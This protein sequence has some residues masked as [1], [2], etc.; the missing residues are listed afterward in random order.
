[1][2]SRNLFLVGVL[3][4]A[5]YNKITE[6]VFLK[7]LKN[8]IYLNKYK[9]VSKFI[10]SK[11]KV[12]IEG[13]YGLHYIRP[14]NIN[15]QKGL[16]VKNAVDQTSYILN[17]LK[18]IKSNQFEYP[19]FTFRAVKDKI[20]IVCIKCRLSFSQELNAHIKGQGCPDCA[21]PGAPS[22]TNE[23]FLKRVKIFNKDLDILEVYKGYHK[24]LLFRNKYGLCKL[25]PEYLMSGSE[26]TLRVAVNKTEYMK[27]QFIEKHG[28]KYTYP[29]F[30]YNGNREYA[31]INCKDHGEFEQLTDVHLMGSGC[32]KCANKNRLS[33]FSRSEFTL[34]AKDRTCV[35]YIIECFK[36]GERFYKMGITSHTVKKRYDTILKMPY[37]YEVIIVHNDSNAGNVWDI[38]MFFKLEYKG[39]QFETNNYFKGS[40]TECYTMD[41]PIKEIKYH[42]NKIS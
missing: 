34:I 13:E 17:R 39:F 42:L 29:N 15:K 19:N 12:F 35:F 32:P 14:M 3:F 4:M 31:K 9:K 30:I 1:M 2:E 28:S 11:E 7:R 20:D 24:H 41:L 33:G 8:N 25:P 6:K 22:L 36:D 37:N 40:I 26:G 5:V 38:E 18:D 27:S 21:T 23:E 10:S 16:N